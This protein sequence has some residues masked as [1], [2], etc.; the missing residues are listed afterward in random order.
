MTLRPW[1]LDKK[2]IKVLPGITG[3]LLQLPFIHLV[4]PVEHAV[5]VVACLSF[6]SAPVVALTP[7]SHSITVAGNSLVRRSVKPAF[8][9]YTLN[10]RFGRTDEN[11]AHLPKALELNPDQAETHN[12]LGILLT[13]MG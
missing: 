9:A 12:N 4:I 7:L 11:M 6:D 5:G 10:L 8:L 3:H 2:D 1:I 13:K